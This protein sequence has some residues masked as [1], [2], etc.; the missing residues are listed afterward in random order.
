MTDPVLD[1]TTSAPLPHAAALDLQE[2]E[3]AVTL[4]MLRSLLPAQ[5]NRHVPDCPAWD[6]RQ[7]YLHVLGSCEGART[8]EMLHQMQAAMRRRRREGG[9]LEASLSAV[10]VEDRAS[11]TPKQL[12]QRL[13]ATAERTVRARRRVPG[14]V[15]S[16][17]RMKV[18]G[19]VVERWSL[20][21]LLGTIYLRDL[22]MHRLDAARALGHSPRLTAE[23]DGRIVA[24]VV[25]EWARRH[26]R[27]FTLLLH[28]PAGGS[29]RA[30]NTADGERIGMDAVEFCRTVSGRAPAS[31]LLTTV[32]PF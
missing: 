8:G 3:L 30:G 18:D 29:F 15:R 1:L 17:V 9:T 5:W 31:G 10:Q 24:D 21:Y 19:P 22:W 20:G 25:A 14:L 11:L 26:G 6:I 13:D 23:H 7:M 27:P 2:R 12:I 28:G 16:A 4:Q 32:V